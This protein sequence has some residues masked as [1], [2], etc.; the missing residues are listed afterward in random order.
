MH[1][2]Q[3]LIYIWAVSIL[4]LLIALAIKR[5]TNKSFFDEGLDRIYNTVSEITDSR[6]AAKII[7]TA[8]IFALAPFIAFIGMI[9]SVKKIVG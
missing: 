3:V 1:T 6:N 8:F 5:L 4:M 2:L 9:N 7:I